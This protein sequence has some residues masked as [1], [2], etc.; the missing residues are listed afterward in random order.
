MCILRCAVVWV[1]TI[2]NS[3]LFIWDTGIM[4]P[5]YW[6]MLGMKK[7]A[8]RNAESKFVHMIPNVRKNPCI[9][10]KPR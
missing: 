2:Q 5:P 3:H 10:R 7:V 8:R 1:L 6:I 4:Y 9:V